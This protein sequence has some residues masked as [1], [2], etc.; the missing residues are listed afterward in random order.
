MKQWTL[1]DIEWERFD[2]TKV[3]PELVKAVK[4]ASLVEHNGYD[5]ETYLH[6]VFHDDAEFCEATTAWAK[7]E[8]R[9][10]KN[11]AKWDE[12]ADPDYDFETS[13]KRFTDGYSLPLDTKMSV[14][15][16]RAGELVARCIVETGTSSYYTAL[17]EAAEEP[18]LKQICK[19]IA[20]DE[21]RHYKLFY[22]H[23][24]RYLERDRIGKLRRLLVVLGRLNESEDD[25]LAYAYYSANAPSD[26][27]YERRRFTRA[28]A[29]RAYGVY[30]PRHIERVVSMSFKAAG[31]QRQ[32]RLRQL[33][34]GV[35]YRYVASRAERL[36]RADA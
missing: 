31:I 1:D 29:R 28:H 26:Q 17:S 30:R 22:T 32:D 15:G 8:V 13:F 16:T 23:M 6:N 9:N 19:N 11:L 35:G 5:Y 20:G 3:D 14:R 21:F 33:L 12:L 24:N 4:A 34:V 18:V 36:R 27:P 10:G 2:P 7:E 25:E